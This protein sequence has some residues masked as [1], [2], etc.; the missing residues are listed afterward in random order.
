MDNGCTQCFSLAA[1]CRKATDELWQ[2]NITN[3]HLLEEISKVKT[4]AENA[5]ARLEELRRLVTSTP[6]CDEALRRLGEK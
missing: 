5:E 1:K 3:H 4:R 6:K 2:A